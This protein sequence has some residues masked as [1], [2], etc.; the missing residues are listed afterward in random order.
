LESRAYH[1][2]NIVARKFAQQ[3]SAWRG[4]GPVIILPVVFL[5]FT[6]TE[7]PRWV[8]MWLLAVVIFVGCKWLTWRRTLAPG[9]QWWQHAGY[10]LAWPGLDASAFLSNKR[11]PEKD[12][13][14]A[15]EWGLAVI[16]LLIGITLF[17]GVAGW[18]SEDHKILSGWVGMVG[19]ILMLHFGAF[20]LLSC[21][22]RS[23]G[24][25]ARP[26]MNRPLASVSVGEFWGRRWNSLSGFDAPL[27]LPSAKLKAWTT[28]SDLGRL[29]I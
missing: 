7:W 29:R 12:R 26:L 27:S 17:W 13:V 2:E 28:P 18:I 1:K 10:L 4:W 19:L 21:A 25:D 11:L 3:I 14:Q 5:I 24:I 15:R 9:A 22:W 6:P 8:F 20:H 23:M 16:R